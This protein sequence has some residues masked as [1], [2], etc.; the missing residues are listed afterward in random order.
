MGSEL[1]LTAMAN[2][3][4]QVVRRRDGGLNVTGKMPLRR[5]GTVRRL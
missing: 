2:T 4:H 1:I 5:D 3:N